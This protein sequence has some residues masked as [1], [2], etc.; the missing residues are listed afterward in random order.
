MPPDPSAAP[1]EHPARPDPSTP[2][3][4]VRPEIA[5]LI[6]AD[7]PGLPADAVVGLA[8]LHRY[9]MLHIE[10]VL[11]AARGELTVLDREVL[12]SM[13]TGEVLAENVETEAKERVTTGERL[14]DRV[15]TFGGSWT[16]IVLFF[17]VLAG[18]IA[19]NAVLLARAAFD[20]YPFILLNLVLSCL[21]AVQA[22]VILMSQ[23]RKEAKDRVRAEYDYQVNLKAEL[24]IRLLHDKL[25]HLM[26]HNWQNL[27]ETQRVQ[28]ELLDEVVS[29]LDRL[30]GAGGAP[31]PG[32]E[33]SLFS[34]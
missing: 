13:R 12:E 34:D 15:A 16:F 19:L 10:T 4:L 30:P 9:R 6:R 25:D 28:A 7:H 2:V 21:A 3:A 20:P 29:R 8:D 26:L 23:N 5:A 17:S 1:P 24:E 18:W 31:S 11:K 33:D 32:G 22:P 27:V 14:A